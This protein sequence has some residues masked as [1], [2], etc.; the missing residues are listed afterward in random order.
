MAVLSAGGVFGAAV[1]AH[2]A[3]GAWLR[4]VLLA[5]FFVVENFFGKS[6]RFGRVLCYNGM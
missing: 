6:V 1:A 3:A 4:A 5:A 2:L